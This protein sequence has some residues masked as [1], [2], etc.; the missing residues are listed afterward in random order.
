MKTLS[1][2]IENIKAIKSLMNEVDRLKE[3]SYQLTNSYGSDFSGKESL[4]DFKERTIENEIEIC[5]KISGID[6]NTIVDMCYDFDF[7][8]TILIN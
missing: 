4:I 3:S 2:T 5:S 7:A 8:K 1:L 6:Y